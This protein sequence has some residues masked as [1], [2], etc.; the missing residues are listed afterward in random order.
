MVLP[1]KLPPDF[2]KGRSCQFLAKIH[3]HLP[4][5]HDLRL[6]T[7]GLK[8]L[9]LHMIIRGY[10]LLNAFSRDGTAIFPEEVVERLMG[11]I[12]VDRQAL[13]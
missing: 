2:W 11:K 5:K 8:I 4:R 10:L 9:Q 7:G 3:G 12:Q 6:V 1:P 13:E